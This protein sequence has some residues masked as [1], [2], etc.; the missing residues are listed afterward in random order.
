MFLEHL[1][2]SRLDNVISV[3][4]NAIKPGECSVMHIR[5]VLSSKHYCNLRNVLILK[6]VNLTNM[7]LGDVLLLQLA[8]SMI[9]NHVTID[10]RDGLS[11]KRIIFTKKLT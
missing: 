9:V 10:N 7:S 2:F 5:A 6:M 8:A 1:F 11:L 4:I 3:Y